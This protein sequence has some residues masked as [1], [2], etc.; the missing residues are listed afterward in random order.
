MSRW[1]KAHSYV[2]AIANELYLTTAAK[3]AN[4]KPDIPAYWE[5][6]VRAHDWFLGSGMINPDNLVNDGLT[7][8]CKNNGKDPFTYNTG[9]ILAGL[10]EMAWSSNDNSYNDL[11]NTLAIAGIDHF[12]D[13]DGIL[14]EPCE[15]DWCSTDQQQFKGVLARNVEFMVNRANS[16]PEDARTKYI[17]FLQ[18]NANALLAEKSNEFSLVWG[19]SVQA[20][21]PATIQTQSSALDMLVAA[22]AV[23]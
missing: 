19:V 7:S 1:D 10:T 17:Q 22:A 5:E 23:S 3:L 15:P 13:K 21:R 2:N 8:D 12:T 18:T 11:A 14:R 6:A 9:V 16:M 4:R 20:Q